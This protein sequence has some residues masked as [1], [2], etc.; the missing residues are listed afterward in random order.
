MKYSR[1]FLK[2]WDCFL[3]GML[4][5]GLGLTWKSGQCLHKQQTSD[6]RHKSIWILAHNVSPPAWI[7]SVQIWQLPGDLYI[8]YFPTVISTSKGFST[9]SSN[10][11]I[12][13]CL[14]SLTLST[15]T[16][17]NW[18][19]VLFKILLEYACWLPFSSSLN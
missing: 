8:S 16:F 1:H 12:S 14:T 2:E 13:S 6:I 4:L 10:V 15:R 11:C 5:F 19:E 18:E 7:R 17:N 9:T 3:L